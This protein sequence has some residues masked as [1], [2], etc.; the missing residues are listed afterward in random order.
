MA[1]SPANSHRN[2]RHI[3]G[4]TAV[5]SVQVAKFGVEVDVRSNLAGKPAAKVLAELVQAGMQK[6]AVN[7]QGIRNALSPPDK[8]AITGGA[9][10][11]GRRVQFAGTM[12]KRRTNHE[13][14]A[15]ILGYGNIDDRIQHHR[16]HVTVCTW[17]LRQFQSRGSQRK[18]VEL[19]IEAKSEIFTVV[20]SD[21]S[22]RDATAT[23]NIGVGSAVRKT[24]T[25][26]RIKHPILVVVRL[27]ST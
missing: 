22:R 11:R 12:V 24:G 4:V 25:A 19:D 2:G 14:S 8:E 17:R 5:S 9:W 23:T 27:F 16:K 20:A 6:V 15:P 3:C 10:N 18:I 26:A 21:A 13:V 7:R 1:A